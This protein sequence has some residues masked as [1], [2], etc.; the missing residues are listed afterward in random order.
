MAE[1]YGVMARFETAGALVEAV[2]QMRKAG[3][4]ELEPC[5][6]YPVEGLTEA[7]AFKPRW[8]PILSLAAAILGAAGV[9][10]MQWYASVLSYPFVVG[11]KPL[12]SWPAFLIP[13]FVFG[14]LFAVLGAAVAMLF[15]NR[16]PRPYHP[17]FNISEFERATDDGFFLIV[18]RHDSRYAGGRTVERLRELA[19]VEVW[20]V[21]E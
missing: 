18:S 8:V 15:G 14:L 1:E 21:P 2:K 16:L 11:G 17:A 19:A 13:A 10:F 5:V 12:H 20:E 4:R 9:Y 3:Y 7:M 6:P